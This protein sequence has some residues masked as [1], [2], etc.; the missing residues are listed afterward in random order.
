MNNHLYDAIYTEQGNIFKK[1]KIVWGAF[2]FVHSQLPEKG[3]RDLPALMLYSLDPYYE[4]HYEELI[5]IAES[6]AQNGDPTTMN[7]SPVVKNLSH[8]FI[9]MRKSPLRKK[10]ELT[11]TIEDRTLYVASVLVVR[12]H[13][14][15]NLVTSK[16]VP[17][18]V[19][20]D[21]VWKT[22]VFPEKYW[23]E[24]F[25][26]LTVIDYINNSEE[27]EDIEEEDIENDEEK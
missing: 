1:G 19:D 3:S 6:I 10:W 26:N 27:E 11:I 7:Q 25:W 5:G 24:H 13:L 17:L 14:P 4:E 16:M 9:R 22:L 23:P 15:L 12:K 2:I 21:D 18:L 8:K 20:P